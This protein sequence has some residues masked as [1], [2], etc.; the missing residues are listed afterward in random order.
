MTEDQDKQFVEFVLK[1]IVDNPDDVQVDRTVDE[2]G[3]LLTVTVNPEDM[4]KVIG[5][6]G[7]TAKAIRSLLKVVGA[8]HDARVNMK[9]VEPEGQEGAAAPSVTDAAAGATAAADDVPAQDVSVSE[10][11]AEQRDTEAAEPVRSDDDSQVD[12]ATGEPVEP[13]DKPR[14]DEVV[15]RALGEKSPLDEL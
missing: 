11:T 14:R 3:V 5:K 8:K 1:T 12:E 10:A 13:D 4:G 7:Q 9:I 6:S 15:D 2:M